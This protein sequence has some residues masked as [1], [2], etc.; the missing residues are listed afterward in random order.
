[1]SRFSRRQFSIAALSMGGLAASGALTRTVAN[2]PSQQ[3]IRDK[4]PILRQDGLAFGA[5]D[6]WGDFGG[7]S[8][9]STEALFL[10]WEDV[11][12]ASLRAADSYAAERNRNLLITVEPWSWDEN[13]RVSSDELRRRVLNGTYDGN[14][15][16]I[17]RVA[18]SLSRPVVIRW[19]QE[20]EDTT[21]R[22]SWSGWPPEDFQTAWRRMIGIVRQEAPNARIMWSPKGLPNLAAY[23]PGGDQL[24]LIGLS[25]FGLEQYDELSLGGARAFVEALKPGY[26]LVQPFG[27]EVW[28]A[29]LG[30]EG[31]D[32]YV[33][34]WMNDAT[35]RP[36]EM[37][38]LTEVV[39]FNDR[40]V[41][42]WP[43]NLG[44]PDWRVVRQASL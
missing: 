1:M 8:G 13:W 7:Q 36:A 11:D 16:E 41:H 9:V 38:L 22:F 39:Y 35:L 25:V 6:P 14:M 10:P 19:A 37:D 21:G 34:N 23:F 40:E 3:T 17:S 33:S 12:L 5:Y 28:V 2:L 24:D 30:Y 32:A 29:E 42:P 31:S 20:M 4:R 15:R 44:Q 27:K 43:L 18:G 26:D